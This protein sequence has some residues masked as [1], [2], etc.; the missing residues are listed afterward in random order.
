VFRQIQT[1][2]SLRDVMGF[3]EILNREMDEGSAVTEFVQ[4]MPGTKA[5]TLG[6]VQ[7]KTEKSEGFFDVIARDLENNSLKG[8]LEM[9]YDLYSQFDEFPGR[10]GLFN[11]S[12][13]GISLLLKTQEELQRCQNAIMMAL[14]SPVLGQM[15]D[16][17]QLWKKM[18]GVMNLLD[19]YKEPEPMGMMGGAGEAGAPPPE[20]MAQAEQAAKRRVASM[21]EDEIMELAGV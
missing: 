21:S 10:E 12:V 5:K 13:G 11:I 18:L 16:L 3:L 20:I 1:K 8:L 17:P 6:E 4:G 19:G 14:Q 15:T 2:S 9:T 7:L